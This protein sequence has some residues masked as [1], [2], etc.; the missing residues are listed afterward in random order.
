MSNRNKPQ[1]LIKGID[2]ANDVTNYLKA[3]DS[4]FA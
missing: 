1:N 3:T 2:N 4:S